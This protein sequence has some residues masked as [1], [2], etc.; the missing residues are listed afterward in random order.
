[1]DKADHERYETALNR[2]PVES[3]HR[4]LRL[5]GQK[6]ARTD[7]GPVKEEG[8][9]EGTQVYEVETMQGAFPAR[10]CRAIR[11]RR[12]GAGALGRNEHAPTGAC[13]PFASLTADAIGHDADER[14][15]DG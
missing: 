9:A 11:I 12:R 14:H 6:Y 15:D 13:S 3:V 5:L 4:T 10:A 7:D 2:H 8:Y 1:M